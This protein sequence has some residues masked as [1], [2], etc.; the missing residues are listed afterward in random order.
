MYVSEKKKKKG[1]IPISVSKV[2]IPTPIKTPPE[3]KSD[4]MVVTVRTYG[5]GGDKV[6]SVGEGLVGRDSLE[7]WVLTKCN[8]SEE[9]RES[10]RVKGVGTRHWSTS[11]N[12]RTKEIKGG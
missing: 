1:Y 11:E 7:G 3:E 4:D 6:K 9:E 2:P 5:G 10:V 8:L 12:Q